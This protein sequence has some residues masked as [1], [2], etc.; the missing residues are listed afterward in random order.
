MSDL[1]EELKLVL[2]KIKGDPYIS[3][4]EGSFYVDVMNELVHW[5]SHKNLEDLYHG[6]GD[7]YSAEILGRCW[8]QDGCSFFNADNGC[9][10]TLTYVFLSKN[11]VEYEDLEQMFNPDEEDDD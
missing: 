9:G 8:E 7:S 6:D 2:S 10:E 4:E 3:M 1:F 11:E 5:N